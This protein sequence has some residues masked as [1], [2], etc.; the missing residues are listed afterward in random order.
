MRPAHISSYLNDYPADLP[1][2]KLHRAALRKFFDVRVERHAIVLNPVLS[3]GTE[4]FSYSE[5]V[6]RELPIKE[7]E[8]LFTS[9]DTSTLV[10]LRDFVV[11]GTLAGTAARRHAVSSLDVSDLRHDGSQWNFHFKEKGGKRRLFEV[12][13]GTRERVG[14]GARRRTIYKSPYSPHSFHVA[15]LTDL[16]K[17]KVPEHDI[18]YLAGHADRRTTDLYNRSKRQVTRNIVERISVRLHM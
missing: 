7:Q 1:T 17:Q 13:L 6:T 18:Q 12:G 15:T 14:E 8:R 5:G 10:G 11:L 16:Y 3:V 9:I 2:V 4:K